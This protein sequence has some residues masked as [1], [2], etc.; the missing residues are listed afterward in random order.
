M[1]MRLGSSKNQNAKN[2]KKLNPNNTPEGLR[3]INSIFLI[4]QC[5][6]HHRFDCMNPVFCLIK[7][8]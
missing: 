7:N 1:V 4:S 8:N 5:G 3:F 6:N 2:K